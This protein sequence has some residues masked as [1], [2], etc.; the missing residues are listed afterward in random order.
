VKP[1]ELRLWTFKQ[2]KQTLW[3]FTRK[4]TKLTRLPLVGEVRH[5][6]A[7]Y[8]SSCPYF[9]TWR[10]GFWI[11]TPSSVETSSFLGPTWAGSTWRRQWRAGPTWRR[12]N[13][14]SKTSCF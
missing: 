12:Q 2:K 3:L 9:K 13:A 14:V 8:T 10:F 5:N 6:S 7:Y 11:L 4:R 1:L